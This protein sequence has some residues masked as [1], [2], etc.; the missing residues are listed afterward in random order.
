M[1]DFYVALTGEIF[2]LWITLNAPSYDVD[3]VSVLYQEEQWRYVIYFESQER[4]GNVFI[5]NNNV[6]EEQIYNKSDGSETAE[7]V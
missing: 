3:G 4:F 5:W 6:V 2:Y 1:N 7:K